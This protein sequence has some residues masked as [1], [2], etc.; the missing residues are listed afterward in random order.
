MLTLQEIIKVARQ[1]ETYKRFVPKSDLSDCYIPH[2]L[3]VQRKRT[4]GSKLDA[5]VICVTRPGKW[6]NPFKVESCI[7]AG[8]AESREQ[9]GRLCV[10]CFAEW[11]LKGDLC[12]DWWNELNR[13]SWK[14]MREN[15]HKLKGKRLA[16]FCSLD[17]PCHADILAGFASRL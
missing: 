16:C 17:R 14:W 9:A 1:D 7:E 6:G 13:E 5:D 8:F 3:R 4:R 15:L 12:D 11:L 2:P 10:E